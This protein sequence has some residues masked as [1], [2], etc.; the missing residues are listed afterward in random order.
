MPF[1][2][3]KCDQCRYIGFA[4]YAF[5][6]YDHLL[7]FSDEVNYVWKGRKGL[8]IYLFFLNR[9][10][11]PLAFIELPR[12][13]YLSPDFSYSMCSHFVRYEG[14]TVVIS[15]GIAGIMMILRENFRVNALYGGKC[16]PVQAILGVLWIFQV[17]IYAQLLSMAQAVP[18]SHGIHDCS[19][20][21]NPKD[22]NWAPLSAVGPLIFDTAVIVLT[23]YK[24]CGTL[25]GGMSSTL[26]K[27]LLNDGIFYYVIVFSAN[28]ALTIM[29]VTASPGLQNILGQFAELMT[30][31]M[32]SRITLHLR[33][34]GAHSRGVVFLPDADRPSPGDTRLLD[35]HS[36]NNP[37][38]TA[39][40]PSQGNSGIELGHVSESEGSREG[41]HENREGRVNSAMYAPQVNFRPN[42]GIGCDIGNIG[43]TGDLMT[44]AGIEEVTNGFFS[45]E[46]KMPEAGPTILS[47]L[48]LATS[49]MA[50][51]LGDVAQHDSSKSC[52]VIIQN[53]VY[54]VTE[55]LPEHPGGANII[56][57]Y[58]GKDATA[59]YEPIHP[60]DALEKNLP[61]EKH[62]GAIDVGAVQAI[63]K[64]NVEKKKT[65]DELR[66]EKAQ[67]EK[68]PLSR[69]LNAI[70]M[71][72]VAKKVLSYK[73]WAYYSS[74]GDG[75]ITYAENI[76]AFSRIFFHARIMRPI[77]QCD[78]STTILGFK[79]S[80]PV[81]VSG[82]ALAKLGHPAGEA[83]ITR[84][85][86]RMGTIQMVS[87]HA[88]LSYAQIAEARVREDQPLFFQ[89]YKHKDFRAEERVRDVVRLGYNAI[90]LT[91]DAP[92]AGHRERDIH[93]PF[94]LAEQEREA[95]R[96][97]GNGTE[98]DT[99]QEPDVDEK[100][101]GTAGAMLNSIDRDLSWEKTIPWLRSVTKL[102]IVIK[103]I[104]C[105]EDAVLAAE[106]GVDGIL[107]SNHG[108]RQLDYSLPSIDV[109]YRL[110]KQRPDVF[111]KLEVYMDGGVRRGSDVLKA[112]CLGATAVG[113]G[114]PFLYA[115][116][117]YGEEG[118]ERLI[119]ILETEI[120][121]G[122]RLLGARNV[123]E[124][125]PE[126]VE[127]VNWQP[128][129]AKL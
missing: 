75:E 127:Q 67:K 32:M 51:T 64:A 5:L 53:K 24:T 38:C 19:M 33:A 23:I 73:A 77:S 79:S 108:G 43:D 12:A 109:L 52:W 86:G 129:I 116:S 115:Q 128:I 6:I 27:T 31:T 80:I 106:A 61:P 72:E 118:V 49:T 48:S 124:L 66:V 107:I 83:N 85:C 25:R 8:I 104:Q 117:A 82:A 11:F 45:R 114:R 35:S 97:A 91:V 10:F 71:E 54:D 16:R 120:V 34:T 13:A 113:M 92:V 99:P 42:S 102:P 46:E 95:E 39:H 37:T 26:I 103:G 93:A 110:R 89:L 69:V 78:P 112:L 55:F 59:A 20:F 111:S 101:E 76:R 62:L 14:A 123:S 100:G 1:L 2:E 15:F 36:S 60:P 4:S 84:G 3:K 50:L 81:F 44:A 96:Q 90:F 58:A 56:L 21:F 41:A 57:K 119:R 70:E 65:Q 94:V 98:V 29:I 121:L 105:V 17:A 126:M 30:V 88:S 122:M 18:R 68:P 125:V 7:T 28:L 22:Q 47:A 9:Y 63:K 40:S 74:A 87:S